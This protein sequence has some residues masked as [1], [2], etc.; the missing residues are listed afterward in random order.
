[1]T[2]EKNKYKTKIYWTIVKPNEDFMEAASEG[3]WLEEG[4][5]RKALESGGYGVASL[6]K[7]TIEVVQT[8]SETSFRQCNQ[9]FGADR[10]RHGRRDRRRKVALTKARQP[11]NL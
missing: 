4:P 3:F 5:A 6:Q 1:M 2:D 10:G 9:V 8:I 11:I 7:A